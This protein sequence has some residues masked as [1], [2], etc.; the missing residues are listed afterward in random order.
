MFPKGS[1]PSLLEFNQLFKDSRIFQTSEIP[2]RVST[3]SQ[4]VA[5]LLRRT[6]HGSGMCPG[7]F[8]G[9]QGG[10]RFVALFSLFKSSFSSKLLS[11][12]SNNV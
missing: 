8:F 1:K 7:V 9:H 11:S 3:T 6:W 4:L 2:G 10:N 5:I 12:K